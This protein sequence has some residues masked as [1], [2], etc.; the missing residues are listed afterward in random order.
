MAVKR[1]RLVSVNLIFKCFEYNEDI[2]NIII[3]SVTKISNVKMYGN[4]VT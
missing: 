2:F 3:N 1:L 4:L